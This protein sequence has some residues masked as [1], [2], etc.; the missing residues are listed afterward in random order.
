MGREGEESG[1]LFCFEA[2]SWRPR[3]HATQGP[4]GL[5]PP[6]R[7][8]VACAFCA[9]A[10][11][12]RE[13]PGRL[14]VHLPRERL[15]RRCPQK[16]RWVEAVGG[17]G[18]GVVSHRSESLLGA[19]LSDSARNFLLLT[20]SQRPAEG[21][22][23]MKVPDFETTGC[24]ESFCLYNKRKITEGRFPVPR[25]QRGWAGAG[26]LR[27]RAP[28]VSYEMKNLSRSLQKQEA[29]TERSWDYVNRTVRNAGGSLPVGMTMTGDKSEGNSQAIKCWCAQE[30][31]EAGLG[32]GWGVEP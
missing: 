22:V 9:A 21:R 31:A 19:V 24:V 17:G 32:V 25:R 11:S 20:G 15:P 2:A 29:G 10:P 7:P 28:L 13:N 8:C 6:G 30:G 14:Q 16:Q 4:A 3:N 1:G 23:C 27:A 12:G 26:R 18:R 5:L